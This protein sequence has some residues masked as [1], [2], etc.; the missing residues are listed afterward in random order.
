TLHQLELLL[1]PWIAHW[2][3]AQQDEGTHS[4]D[5]F[6]NLRLT[7]WTF[8]WQVAQAGAS[9]R[10]AIR[11]A[12]AL[13][14]ISGRPVPPDKTSP[15][16]QARGALPLERLQQIHEAIVTEAQGAIG[17]GD[18]WCGKKVLAV[19]GSTVTM[20]DTPANQKAYP[21]QSVQKPGC[22]FPILRLVAFFCLATGFLNAWATG[23]WHDHEMTL[24]QLL[25]HYLRPDDVLLAD[26]GFCSWGLLAQ[27]Q[28]RQIHAVF[29][30]RGSR[31]TD[32]R[33][34][35][36]LSKDER[37][38]TWTKPSLRQDRR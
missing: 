31:R 26:R 30:V 11:Q 38:V 16:C 27:C 18:L 10:E 20:P 15:Y 14:Q 22:G 1:G 32:F 7:F 6:W 28:R 4:R 25:W 35:Q 33:R 5:R 24:I 13:C 12:Q 9:C 2:R 29:R 21:Q 19:D 3:L 36:R 37:L 23:T 34:G 8:L 17:T